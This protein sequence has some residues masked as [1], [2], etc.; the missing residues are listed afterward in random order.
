MT[1]NKVN[2]EFEHRIKQLTKELEEEIDRANYWGIRNAKLQIR[3]IKLEEKL[4]KGKK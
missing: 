4:K 2:L 3:I 1:E